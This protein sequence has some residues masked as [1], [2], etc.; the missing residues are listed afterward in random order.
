M[1]GYTRPP[2]ARHLTEEPVE[3][4]EAQATSAGVAQAGIVF[5][6]LERAAELVPGTLFVKFCGMTAAWRRRTSTRTL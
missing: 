5:P 1:T 4:G 3:D 6:S 2:F